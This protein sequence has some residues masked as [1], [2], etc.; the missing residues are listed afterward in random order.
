MAS[1]FVRVPF[2]FSE[3]SG[4]GG[5]IEFVEWVS[6]PQKENDVHADRNMRSVR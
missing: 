5:G 3:R 4:S 2:I 6:S 1:S